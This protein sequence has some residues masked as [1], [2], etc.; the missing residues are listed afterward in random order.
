[1]PCY[2]VAR[3]AVLTV[4]RTTMPRARHGVKFCGDQSA[5]R[6]QAS[7]H[8]SDRRVGGLALA[9]V[10]AISDAVRKDPTPVAGL[11]PA[12]LSSAQPR[13]VFTY[14]YY[15]YDL[16][17]G[18]HSSSLTDHPAEPDASYQNA[19]WFTK[20]LLDME[21]AGIDGAL[22]VYW[23]PAEP[24]SDIGLENMANAAAELP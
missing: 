1:M 24:S 17:S 20:Q 12:L 5:E 3:R 6:P 15:W 7:T 16:P 4:G 13:L 9:V 21:D 10:S 18:P 2:S 8:F 22:A 23:G 11:E 14:F 19:G